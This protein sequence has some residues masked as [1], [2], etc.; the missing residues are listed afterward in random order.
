M[1]VESAN[2]RQNLR[3]G[4]GKE[5]I[6]KRKKEKERKEEKKTTTYGE[7]VAKATYFALGVDRKRR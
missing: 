3:K 7:Q 2:T 6:T 1:P 4:R 5:N